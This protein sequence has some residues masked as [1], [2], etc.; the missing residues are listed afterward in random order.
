MVSLGTTGYWA[1]S[2]WDEAS[3]KH[4]IGCARLMVL[5]LMKVERTGL[6]RGLKKSRER[7]REGTQH[8]R[9]DV[10]DPFV[11]RSGLKETCHPESRA[12][13]DMT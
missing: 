9:D 2:P 3:R 7:G 12:S 4:V 5:P 6:R 1:Y 11:L 8:L 10:L 13:A